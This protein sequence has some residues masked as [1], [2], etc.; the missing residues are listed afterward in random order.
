MREAWKYYRTALVSKLKFYDNPPAIKVS[1]ESEQEKALATAREIADLRTERKSWLGK[2][3]AYPLVNPR[4]CTAYY[5][6][7]LAAMTIF[8]NEAT[9][10]DDLCSAV[11]GYLEKT[12]GK[13]IAL[14]FWKDLKPEDSLSESAQT[15]IYLLGQSKPI[16]LLQNGGFESGDTKGWEI[17]TNGCQI[18]VSKEEVHQGNYTLKLVGGYTT[19]VLSQK[20]PV[21]SRERY[22]LTAWIKYLTAP[23]YADSVPAESR[24]EFYAGGKQIIDEPTRNILRTTSPSAGWMRLCSTVTI[25]PGADTALIKLRR[26]YNCTA[27]LDEVIF[28]KIKAAP[29]I[30]TGALADTFGGKNLD[31]EK[32]FQTTGSRG[33]IPPR[34][35]DGW[36]IYDDAAMYSITSYAKFNDL[37]K[38]TG[39]NRYCLRLH[40][41][42]LSDDAKP[43]SFSWGI[44]TGT[45]PINISD[46]GMFWTYH[47]R[48]TEQPNAQLLCYAYQDSKFI[49]SGGGWYGINRLSNANEIWYTLYFDP[50]YVTIYASA[51]GY[52]ES[53]ASLVARYKHEINDIAANGD[54]YLKMDAGSYKLAEITLTRP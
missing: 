4:I 23:V 22:R 34:I 7:N 48:S 15:Q 20:V 1:S 25:P 36:L 12:V 29:E 35:A 33:T 51:N 11:T 6:G 43:I 40:A 10:L 42:K 26:T 47:F 13:E 5:W 30:K 41:A 28:E 14:K 38:Y 27:L 24:I 2:M 49:P 19:P 9:L 54:V 32:W 46:S 31:Q 45:G 8:N 21:S 3:R 37:L 39:E 16:N 50:E 18:S 53:E 17:A 44:K 52:D